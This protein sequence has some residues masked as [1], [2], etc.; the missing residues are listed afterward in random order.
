MIIK[1]NLCGL[2]LINTLLLFDKS[3]AKLH[4]QTLPQREEEL[5]FSSY[6]QC[7]CKFEFITSYMPY[8][9]FIDI[10]YIIL[11]NWETMHLRTTHLYKNI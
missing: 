3:L 2:T 10:Y 5:W 11:N 8:Y 9:Y 4:F 6:T 7:Q 1:S